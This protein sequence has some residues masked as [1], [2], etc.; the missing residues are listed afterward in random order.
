M[1]TQ[2]FALRCR[3]NY[4][5]NHTQSVCFLYS[6]WCLWGLFV[7]RFP[8]ELNQHESIPMYSFTKEANQR[9]A[10]RSLV[11]NG[12]LANRGLTCLVKEA[13]GHSTG[14]RPFLTILGHSVRTVSRH[15]VRTV[16]S[17]LRYW[18][19]M[20][21]VQI[22]LIAVWKRVFGWRNVIW[23]GQWLKAS[24]SEDEILS[25]HPDRYKTYRTVISSHSFSA[26]KQ[27]HRTTIPRHICPSDLL[28]KPTIHV[29][30]SICYRSK[31][32][33]WRRLWYWKA[34]GFNSP[35]SG[36]LSMTYGFSSKKTSKANFSCFLYLWPEQAV[37]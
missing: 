27:F 26:V 15:S 31:D 6:L 35:L 18:K 3:P 12:R 21:S 22:S 2:K 4:V 37:Y 33:S 11:F 17:Y 25:P 32:F 8:A 19:K 34:F 36:N 29:M 24:W 1:C 9:L 23:W 7:V 28:P 13:T 16:S 20:T 5:S 14:N 10:K 30:L